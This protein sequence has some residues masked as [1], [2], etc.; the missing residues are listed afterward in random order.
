MPVP[1]PPAHQ[2]R[3]RTGI[4]ADAA[5]IA[6]IAAR[7]FT[8]TFGPDNSPVQLAAYVA[9]AFGE[10]QQRRELEDPACTYLLMEVDGSLGAFALLRHGA[11]SPVVQ[12]EAPVEIQRFYV[13]HDFH[14]SGVA[15]QLM[16][17]CMDTASQHQGRTLWLGVWEENP[18]AI[19]FYEKRGFVD[20]GSALFH[21]GSDVQHDRVMTRPIDAARTPEKVNLVEAFASFTD[22]WQ[23]RVAGRLNGQ[24]IKLVKFQGPFIWHHHDHEDELFLVHRGRFTMEFRDRAVVLEAGDLLIVPR[25]VEHR[26]VADEEV[27]V[28][29]F[30]LAGTLNTGNV[31]NERTVEQ[32][33]SL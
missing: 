29:V 5:A 15:A 32:P 12:G 26:P 30:E 33:Q 16:D 25:G 20:V 3:I 22:H 10:I 28:I 8:R 23:Q 9:S 6:S 1:P 7:I 18:R 11:T 14:G 27:E 21:M 31:R 13:D 4:P 19:R 24:E 2:L 17:A